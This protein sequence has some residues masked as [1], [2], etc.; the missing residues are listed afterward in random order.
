MKFQNHAA[1]ASTLT[2]KDC[3]CFSNYVD[4]A[5]FLIET[6][7]NCWLSRKRRNLWKHKNSSFFHP[8]HLQW[9]SLLCQAFRITVFGKKL[10]RKKTQTWCIFGCVCNWRRDQNELFLNLLWKLSNTSWY[11][12]YDHSWGDGS[13]N[14]AICQKLGITLL[15]VVPAQL[16]S[17]FRSAM[18]SVSPRSISVCLGCLWIFLF[19]CKIL[20]SLLFCMLTSSKQSSDKAPSRE[21]RFQLLQQHFCNSSPTFQLS[22]KRATSR[23]MKILT[24]K[25]RKW[26]Y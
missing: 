19:F 4:D 23:K 21:T 8:K 12:N 16:P 9:S 2:E 10:A 26:V 20:L 25:Q 1:C 24:I 17:Q 5:R 14:R 15:V 11:V 18:C 3:S 13:F 7:S 6:D 22:C